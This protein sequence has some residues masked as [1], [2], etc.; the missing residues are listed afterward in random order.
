MTCCKFSL[1]NGALILISMI[2]SEIANN[3]WINAEKGIITNE[4]AT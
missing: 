1:G 4:E 3:F 2:E